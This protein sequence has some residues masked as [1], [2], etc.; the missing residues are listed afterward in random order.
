MCD[1]M[2]RKHV[3]G[4]PWKVLYVRLKNPVEGE[5][6]DRI[7]IDEVAYDEQGNWLTKKTYALKKKK[8]KKRLIGEIEREIVYY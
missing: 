1:S 7:E 3:V 5:E 6:D 4:M 2:P 8:T